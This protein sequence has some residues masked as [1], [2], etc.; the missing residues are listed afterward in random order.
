MESIHPVA[1]IHM[2]TIMNYW[3]IETNVSSATEYRGDQIT[4]SLARVTDTRITIAI[5]VSALSV[6]QPRTKHPQKLQ[7]STYG[8]HFRGS[9]QATSAKQW[10]KKKQHTKPSKLSLF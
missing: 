7:P 1:D 10:R 4:D 5:T 2:P 8:H 9:G 6:G 3:D